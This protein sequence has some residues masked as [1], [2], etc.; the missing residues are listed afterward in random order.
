M[1]KLIM[2]CIVLTCAAILSGCG[3]SSVEAES[4]S[5]SK[6]AV[7]GNSCIEA[8]E[9]FY[10]ALRTDDRE[11]SNEMFQKVVHPY[12]LEDLKRDRNLRKIFREIADS[13]EEV[14][15]EVVKEEE[16]QGGRK[17]SIVRATCN[18]KTLY[19]AVCTEEDGRK[20]VT[21]TDDR[22]AIGLR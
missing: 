13:K 3:N 9:D 11:K 15:A 7:S 10:A 18:S 21:I 1:K 4:R 20:I 17:K 12:C 5:P 19:F 6:E 22:F 16:L 14:I 8:V 2:C